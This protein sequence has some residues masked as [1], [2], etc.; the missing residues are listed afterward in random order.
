MRTGDSYKKICFVT[1]AR[2]EYGLLKWLMKAVEEEECFKLQLI[3][4]GGHLL[5]EQ[6]HTVDEIIGDGFSIDAE[7]KLDQYDDSSLMIA[8]SMN[9]L[10]LD[11]AGVFDKLQPD[12]LVILGDRYELLPICYT[13]L[14]M[15]I[16]IAH[17]C[18]GDV[19]KG[20][21]DDKIRNAVTMMATYHFPGTKDSADNIIR[22]RGE[23]KNIWIVGEPS[24]ENILKNEDM[25]REDLAYHLGL[26]EDKRWILY[27]CHS[28][29][30]NT[31][32]FN[33]QMI[34]NSI[35]VLLSM[36]N[37][38]IVA[39]YANLD[40]GGRHINKMLEEYSEQNNEKLKVIPSLGIRKYISFLKQAE[41][42][43]GNSSSGIVETPFFRLPTVNIGNRQ[44]GRYMCSNIV[45]CGIKKEDIKEAID[46]TLEKKYDR[47]DFDYWGDGKT[48]AKILEHMKGVI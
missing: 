35:E 30:E 33:L 36:D 6:G 41:L 2:S 16:P 19:T 25:T 12:C 26:E 4:T 20:A 17:L 39:T 37:V 32:D 5:Q 10:G 27:T 11:L 43:V 8:K 13:A 46:M 23:E 22:M 29:T 7:V 21:I 44:E 14:V 45:S 42:M 40:Q 48:S 9:K 3:V 28:E 34:K 1:A 47:D 18:G 24:I 38:Q 15:R 31:L